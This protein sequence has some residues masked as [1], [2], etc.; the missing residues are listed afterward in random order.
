MREVLYTL[1]IS[2]KQL[3]GK[4]LV[5]NRIEF[6]LT[7]FLYDEKLNDE[8]ISRYPRHEEQIRTFVRLIR[9]SI[10]MNSPA[11]TTSTLGRCLSPSRNMIRR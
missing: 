8:I 11:A 3:E 9:R 7:H 2:V 6:G 4:Y 1:G 10:T 5:Q